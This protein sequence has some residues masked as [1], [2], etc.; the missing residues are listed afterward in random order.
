MRSITFALGVQG[1][2]MVRPALAFALG[3]SAAIPLAALPKNK[4]YRN[5]IGFK[6]L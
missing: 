2:P 5:L 6:N 4:T 3:G 1:T